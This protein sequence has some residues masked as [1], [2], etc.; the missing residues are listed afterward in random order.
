MNADREV[1][2]DNSN[3]LKL[4]AEIAMMARYDE[5]KS[6]VNSFI[7]AHG[8][9]NSILIDEENCN[10]PAITDA[11][12]SLTLRHSSATSS[13]AP[14]CIISVSKIGNMR[15]ANIYTIGIDYHDISLKDE[16]LYKIYQDTLKF[17]TLFVEVLPSYQNLLNSFG[18]YDADI[19]AFLQSRKDIDKYDT[20]L[21]N[22]KL[23][24]ANSNLAVGMTIRIPSYKHVVID[25]IT[26]KRI[27][28]KNYCNGN[29]RS[30]DRD[31]AAKM[32]VDQ[33]WTLDDTQH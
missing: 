1:L 18:T 29:R 20:D 17:V 5:M 3:A 8:L 31:Y 15:Y 9:D 16:S 33:R 4:S 19:D 13:P 32:I 14:R 26:K 11:Y 21:R 12:P 2:V 25:R 23:A 27:F 7:S 10:K 22:A 28:F 30:F 6:F 24:I